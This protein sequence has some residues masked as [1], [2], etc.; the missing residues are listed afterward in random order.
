MLIFNRFK[1]F[2]LSVIFM[3]TFL[4]T[5][6]SEAKVSLKDQLITAAYDGNLSKVRSLINQGTDI[7][8]MDN[9]NATILMLA[10]LG[11]HVE[12][13]RFL[14]QSGADVNLKGDKGV[15]ALMVG[16]FANSDILV[17]MFLES[18][19]KVD[20]KF[21]GVTALMVASEIGNLDI[22]RMLVEAGADINLKNDYGKTALSY[23][24]L[25]G[26]VKVIEYLKSKGAK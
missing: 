11:S 19:A 10:A 18:G 17:R 7:N 23:A 8:A 1:V 26:N 20:D 9:N 4:F 14:L 22:V 2:A 5:T 16:I 24:V 13:V 21:N 6:M 25:K 12:V 3:I 15:T